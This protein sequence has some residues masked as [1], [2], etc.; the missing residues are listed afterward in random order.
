MLFDYFTSPFAVQSANNGKIDGI[1]SGILAFLL[2]QI[3]AAIEGMDLLEPF[4]IRIFYFCFALGLFYLVYEILIKRTGPMWNI[5]PFILLSL[6]LFYFGVQFSHQVHGDG[7]IGFATFMVVELFSIGFG[8]SPVTA[9]ILNQPAKIFSAE[10]M[11]EYGI[12]GINQNSA[13][14]AFFSNPWLLAVIGDQLSSRLDDVPSAGFFVD[15]PLTILALL[16][17]VIIIISFWAMAITVFL[18]I[19][20][21]KFFTVVGSLMLPLMLVPPFRQTGQAAINS[22]IVFCVKFIVYGMIL[23]VVFVGIANL[24]SQINTI[25]TGG[26]TFTSD[27]MVYLCIL[28]VMFAY[29]ILLI[30]AKIAQMFG[31][32][33]AFGD[34]QVTSLFNK[35][36]LGSVGFAAASAFAASRTVASTT[37]RAA[38]Q[39]KFGGAGLANVLL[40]RNAASKT[41]HLLRAAVEGVASPGEYLAGKFRG[42]ELKKSKTKEVKILGSALGSAANV[43]KSGIASQGVA[44][45]AKKAAEVAE[46][47]QKHRSENPIKLKPATDDAVD[48]SKHDFHTMDSS[49]QGSG[50]AGATAA[51]KSGSPPQSS[52]TAAPTSKTPKTNSSSGSTK[53]NDLD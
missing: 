47:A 23:T 29:L 12:R 26:K 27:D 13:P 24:I 53:Y 3:D 46:E 17:K 30:P 42:E 14:A 19:V 31:G 18:N 21:F 6:V 52:E 1:G 16:T 10:V 34:G 9:D 44:A 43:I 39:A 7:F 41:G 48:T 35:A 25:Y 4:I 36:V 8:L 49:Q 45:T 22:L 5:L 40:N 2:A 33:I 37:G 50:A 28:C 20:L 11:A 32:G 51:S 38:L 15:F